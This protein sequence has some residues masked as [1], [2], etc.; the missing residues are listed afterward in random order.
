[1][2]YKKLIQTFLEKNHLPNI[3]EDKQALKAIGE[4]FSLF[5]NEKVNISL[6]KEWARGMQFEA[7]EVVFFAGTFDPFHQGHQECLDKCPV[8]NIIVM[9]DL[10]PWK[11]NRERQNS[12]LDSYLT[13][14]KTIKYCVYPGFLALDHS[15]PTSDWIKNVDVKRK[16]LLM[17]A[18]TFMA[19]PRWKNPD[20]LLSNLTGLYILSRKIGHKLIR[21]QA[22]SF[23]ANYQNLSIVFI[24]D[25]PYEDL[26]SCKLRE[27]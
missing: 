3:N 25:N 21:E 19:I 14:L 18:D 4:L 15:N 2:D 11:E 13:L 24:E 20:I 12:E 27:K 10:N 23:Q 6:P 1:M 7:E 9:P 8:K 5:N 16:F 17:G 22:D 26:S